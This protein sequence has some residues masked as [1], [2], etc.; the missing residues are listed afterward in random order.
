MGF[1]RDHVVPWLIDRAMANE[2]LLDYRRRVVGAAR[3][4]VLEIGIGSGHNLPFYGPGVTGILGIEPSQR[5]ISQARQRANATKQIVD[6]LHGSAE[7]I[8][9]EAGSIDAIV[10][11]WTLCSIPDVAAALGE[12][13]RVLKSD[14]ELLFVEHGHAPD[15]PVARLQDLLTP[16]WQHIAGGCHLNRP[17]EALIQAAGF[18]TTELRT[19]YAPGPRPFTFMYEGRARP[20]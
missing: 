6:F 18:R 15:R 17:I 14:G 10:T 4:R 7:A 16:A 1:Y 5:L 19:G 13:R 11:T 8:P 2:E 9:L 3:G 20:A 12:M